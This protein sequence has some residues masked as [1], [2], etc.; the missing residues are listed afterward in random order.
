MKKYTRKNPS[1]TYHIP[2][3]EAGGWRVECAPKGGYAIFAPFVDRLGMYEDLFGA[4]EIENLNREQRNR[5]AA[6]IS[7]L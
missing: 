4:K 7:A 3:N 5:L 2:D 6:F 1:G